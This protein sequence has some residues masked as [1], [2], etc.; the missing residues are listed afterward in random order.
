MIVLVFVL[1][2]GVSSAPVEV[3]DL[4]PIIMPKEEE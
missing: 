1:L 3:P 2:F 4:P